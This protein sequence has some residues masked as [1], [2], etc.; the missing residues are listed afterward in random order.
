MSASIFDIQRELILDTIRKN[1]PGEWKVLILDQTSRKLV[2]NVVN[3]DDI[4]KENVLKIEDIEAR[5]QSDPESDVIYILTPEQHIVDCLMA[6]LEKR[7]YRR[8][9]LVW[10]S[11]LPPEQRQ[12]IDRSSSGRDQIAKLGITHLDFYP[13]ESHLVTFRD[14][15]S[16][17]I[18]YHPRC[19]NLVQKHISDL[20]QKIVGIC[21]AL[22]EYPTIR[23]YKPKD[24]L[25]SHEAHVL[26]DF[27]A[28]AVQDEIDMYRKYHQDSFPPATTRPKGALYILDRSM[29]L[30]SPFL[31]EFTY[32]AMAHDLLPI[33]DGDKVTFRTLINEGRPDA[34][35]KEM[36]IGEKDQLWVENRHRHM[37]DTLEKLMSDFKK[38]LKEN[39]H[40]ANSGN[41]SSLN[42]IKDMLAGLP[43]FQEMKDAY[44][45]H[46]NMA[47]GCMEIFQK[48]KLPE[49]ALLEQTLATGLDEDYRKPKGLAD[50]LVRI[51][52]EADVTPAD[53]LR[54]LALFSIYQDG[55]IPADRNR[56]FA[57]A[58]LPPSDESILLNLSLLGARSDRPLGTKRPPRPPTRPSR[59]PRRPPNEFHALTQENASSA[60]LRTTERAKPTWARSRLNSVEP[61]QR[62]VVFIAGGA[63]FS[64]A[65]ACYEVSRAT[66]RDVYLATSHMLTPALFLRQLGDLSRDRA[67]LRIPALMPRPKAPAHLFEERPAVGSTPS[68]GSGRSGR[69]VG[70]AGGPGQGLPIRPGASRSVTEESQAPSSSATSQNGGGNERNERNGGKLTKDPDRKKKKL[71]FLSKK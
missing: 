33:R 70:M 32:Q 26:S 23:Y 25:P 43:Q 19:S 56:L 20:A 45:L 36:E 48:H 71:H 46:I 60:S 38:F 34:E 55:L 2:E 52:D 12:R 10:T 31:H 27:I 35:E 64:E 40:F 41:A 65:R 22:G 69:P 62:V 1:A 47:E 54:L 13:R 66:G 61:R 57:H 29:D 24:P 28:Q 16:F 8:T 59:S 37:R 49:I 9:F 53:R 42:A 67:Q 44:T 30:F 15:W 7:R 18:L 51:V 58:A 11:I 21:I 4:I 39:P 50:Q 68:G 6:D 17:P 5:R 14:P 3:E 63:T